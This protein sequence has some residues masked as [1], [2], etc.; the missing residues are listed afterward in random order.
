M[1][2][3]F[4]YIIIGA[5]SA[6]SVLANR[7][8][9]GPATVALLEAGP[10]DRNPF[11]H[12]PAGFIKTLVNP[13]VNWLYDTE[14]AEGT[15]GRRIATPRGKTLGGSSSI[16]GHI[17]N[18]GQRLDFDTWAQMGNRG[19]GYTD[20]L[21]YFQRS[22]YR[23]G[24]GDDAYR[25]REGELVVTDIEKPDPICDAFIDG[26]ANMGIP[27]ARDYN[28]AVQEGV[29]YFQRTIHKGRR[30]SAARAFLNPARGR[31]NLDIRTGVHVTRIL[32][33]GRR[34]VGVEYRRGGQIH[35]LRAN[36]E[37]LLAAG[38]IASP[39]LLQVSGI[40]DPAHLNGIGVPVLHAL[41]GVGE[42]LSDHYGV[43]L[44]ARVRNART[45]N[46]RT[47]G[48]ALAGEVAKYLLFRK[49]VLAQSPGVTLALCKSRP[50]LEQPDLQ[51]IFAPASY[52]EDAAYKLDDFPG[53]T[54]GS[55]P[56]RPESRGHVRARSADT[57]DKPEIQP[58]Y[59]AAE[60]DQ[61]LI[62]ESTKLARRMIRTPE[63]AHWFERENTPGDAVQSDDELLAYAREHGTT[64][65]HLMGSCKMGPAHD[66]QAVVSDTLHVHGIEGLRVIDASVIPTSHSA[67]TNA[68]TIM[69]A[70]KASDMIL[71]KAPLPPAPT[72]FENSWGVSDARENV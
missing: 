14:P 27:R 71:G 65:F 46:E 24:D 18:R 42:N 5:G 64:I 2:D 70:E 12:I 10:P 31:T 22:E 68:A 34:A 11:I 7:L 44:A 29:G 38:A 41:T 48:L 20:V 49:G 57:G 17:Y 63:L 1:A 53:M 35:E 55:W 33:E 21:P 9:T 3:S 45:L 23:I 62:V 59:L 16:N 72:Y 19:W 40:G 6:G 69:I 8:T 61:R 50:A 28:G 36:R 52:K 56:M 15:A 47:R 54:I 30:M 51:V 13:R 66:S 67:N 58:N 43:R 25:G 60:A 32:F 4:D 26:V 37:V 39:Q